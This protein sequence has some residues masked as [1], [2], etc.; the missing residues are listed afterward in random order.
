[1]CLDA[2]RLQKISA[3]ERE[4]AARVIVGPHAPSFI[5]G[6]RKLAISRFRQNKQH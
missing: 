3:L 1:V 5:N 2:A 4:A 6:E